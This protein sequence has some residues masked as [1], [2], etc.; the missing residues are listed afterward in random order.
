[1]PPSRASAI[2]SRDSVT[3]SIAAETIGIASSIRGVSRVA[4]RDLARE[5]VR[6][7]RLE[8]HV[9]EGE[10]LARE[11]AAHRDEPLDV[12]RPELKLH[13]NLPGDTSAQAAQLPGRKMSLS[14]RTFKSGSRL[15]RHPDGTGSSSADLDGACEAR[16]LARVEAARA[17]LERGRR[18]GRDGAAERVLRAAGRRRARRGTLPAARRPSRPPRRPRPAAQRRAAGAATR[19]SRSSA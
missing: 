8:Q 17:D 13:E 3:V 11:L 10:A 12:L 1:M 2:A 6:G 19:S 9:V 18:P 5:H 15:P 4:S 16:R 7:G 14:M